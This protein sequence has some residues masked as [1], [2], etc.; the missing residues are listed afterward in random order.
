MPFKTIINIALYQSAWFAS[1]LGAAYHQPWLGLE[2][3]GIVL[4]W[5]FIQVEHPSEEAKLILVTLLIG[6]VF[7]Q[8]LVSTQLIHYQAHGWSEAIVPAWILALWLTFATLLNVSL[9]WMRSQLTIAALFGFVGGPL[10]YYAAQALGAISITNNTAYWVL[11]I[12]WAIVTPILMLAA[13]RFDGF[14]TA[15]GITAS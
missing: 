14:H 2:I 5:H 12:G 3:A 6:L 8:A 11:A 7:D 10:A 9:R 13:K 15:K 4:A 1:V